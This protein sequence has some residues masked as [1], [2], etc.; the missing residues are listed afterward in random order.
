MSISFYIYRPQEL[1]KGYY[2]E[3]MNKLEYMSKITKRNLSERLEDFNLLEKLENVSNFRDEENENLC[4]THF[5]PSDEDLEN[6]KLILLLF[7]GVFGRKVIVKTPDVGMSEFQMTILK[8]R[9]GSELRISKMTMK[10]DEDFSS[11]LLTCG[12]GR[13]STTMP[14]SLDGRIW[15]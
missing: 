9:L 7:K 15:R 1:D 12:I 13:V 5:N 10:V 3:F 2:N 14:G 4:F 6:A 8:Y 11:C